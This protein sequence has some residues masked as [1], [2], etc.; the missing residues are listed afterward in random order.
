MADVIGEA[1]VK[2]TGDITPL[3]QAVSKVDQVVAPLKGK[4][5]E[6]FKIR[7]DDKE[8][9]TFQAYT[10]EIRKQ[11]Q[12]FE[13]Y[14]QAQDQVAKSAQ[15]ASESTNTLTQ[16]VAKTADTA[17]QTITPLKTLGGQILN[18]G[19]NIQA[20]V[21]DAKVAIVDAGRVGRTAIIGLSA[22]FVALGKSSI[23]EYAKYNQE[24]AET[25]ERLNTSISHLKASIGQMLT[26][27]SNAVAN[28][29]EWASK[30]PQLVSGILT[31]VGTLAGSAGLIAL[32]TKLAGA[33]TALKTTAGGIIGLISTLA[34]LVAM[35]TMS[36]QSFDNTLA[37]IESRQKETE[38][39]N[40]KVSQS[41]KQMNEAV[42]NAGRSM[43]D[44][45]DEFQQSLK[46]ILVSHEET[47]ETLNQQ[48][49][50]AN[51]EYTQ[52]VNERNQAFLVS[53]AKEEQAHQEKVEELMTQLNFLQRYNNAYNK[54]K[55]EAVKFALAREEA[56]Y[57]KRTEAEKAELDLQ[58]AYDKQKR[59]E[60]L[61]NY[62]KELADERAF[63]QKHAEVFKQVRDT[64]L[65][66]EVE[67][68]LKSFEATKSTYNREVDTAR[69]AYQKMLNDAKI[70]TDQINGYVY[71]EFNGT[72]KKIET[73][74]KKGVDGMY[75]Y[76]AA[77][78]P[79]GAKFT[80]KVISAGAMA[81]ILLASE[82][83]A[84]GGYTGRGGVD[85]VAGVVHR[86]EYVLPQEMVDQTTGTP[87]IGSNITINVSGTFAT[88][89]LERRKVAEQIVQ[90][91]NQTNYARLG[92]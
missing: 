51:K 42:A 80:G 44:S 68:L 55:L 19:K 47:V 53:Q 32:V 82:G 40:N 10:E 24:A 83:Y 12:E 7:Y 29:A 78:S 62:E 15:I 57:K 16:S 3:Q 5:L 1:T 69:Q 28:V 23:K 34:G 52:K 61:A 22:A 45:T 54:E 72:M 41:Y 66:D 30:N 76:G 87:K 60:K 18:F 59:D 77:V 8:F 71:A 84:S 67:N 2:I 64:I 49:E 88:S 25:Q 43:R 73:R 58:N 13:A 48:I 21:L 17:Q 56:L 79:T 85:E 92:V 9:D 89:D 50:E 37:D 86:G 81:Q 35:L 27:L 74:Y 38:E 14:S 91:L 33:I 4:E 26:P 31:I 20:S 36:S 6:G 70:A 11:Q 63:L 90:A 39:W 75:S 65:R 46:K